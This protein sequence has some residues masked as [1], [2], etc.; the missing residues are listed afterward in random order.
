MR[1]AG[2][3]GYY[4]RV[5]SAGTNNIVSSAHYGEILKGFDIRIVSGTGAGQQ[6]V[7]TAVSDPVVAD[8]GVATSVSSTT[9]LLQITDS[10]KNWT[11]NQWVG[12]QVRITYGSGI[13]QVR[14]ILYNSNNTL[15][16]GDVNLF[17]TNPWDAMA[18][19]ATAISSTVG[20]QTVYNIESSTITVD[21]NWI[22]QP[23]ATSRFMV[24][25]GGVFLYTYAT[26]ISA[27]YD[28][29]ADTWYYRSTTNL[30]SGTPTDLTIE[31][32][33]ENSTIWEKGVAT[34]G[35]T[36]TLV[37]NTKQ[38]KV[39][40][41]A[42]YYIR[43]YSGTGENQL[44]QIV[45]NTVDTITWSATGTA[46]DTTS[47][48]LIEGLDAGT[49]SSATSTT[50]VDS[51]KSWGVDRWKNMAVYITSGTGMGQQRSIVSNTSTTLTV[52]PPWNTNPD[53]TSTYK[54]QGDS[55]K[56]F[57]MYGG[58]S[59]LVVHNL[60]RDSMSYGREYENGLCRIGSAR[61]GSDYAI[62]IT[63]TTRSG[64]VATV[65]TA[66]PHNFKTGQSITHLGA[67]GADATLYNITASITVTSTTT[68]TYN[69][70]G[71]PT[72]NAVFNSLS[73]SVLV[74]AAKNWTTN[75]WAGYIVYMNTNQTSPGTSTNTV[76]AFRIA[77][78][79]SN[80]LTFQAAGTAPVNGVSRY[81]IST[82]P[83]IG[84]IDSGLAF[85]AAVTTA[86]VTA[87]T[88]YSILGIPAR[89][90][91]IELNWNQGSSD[92]SKRG[93]FMFVARGGGVSG[94]D[95]LNLNTDTWETMVVSP[96]S[97]T[98]TTG[99]MYVYD[100]Q[101]RIYFTK[102][103]TLR[104]YYLDV[105]TNMIHGAGVYPYAAGTAIIGNRMEIFETPDHLK[106]LW[107][108]RHSAAECFR[109][110]LFY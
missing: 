64:T 50:L 18:P 34:S 2:A 40:Q 55:D 36:T 17:A 6:R 35:T 83:A 58:Q 5:I 25:S 76:Q 54:I 86:A 21:T 78:N 16:F 75:Q 70:S 23:D 79:T 14:K 74:D 39:N 97:E 37:D 101:D 84:A 42:G 66:V 49:T 57:V 109:C 105:N 24:Q 82:A 99:S 71:T 62:P 102:E 3:V 47:R 60:E 13:S 44:R 100:G 27:Y 110:L 51:A 87:N 77:S 29:A 108:N 12:Y 41:F 32:Q 28:I 65:T 10:T 88:T 15:T 56:L 72:A 43:I 33:T 91:G 8:A 31:R 93:R 80:T 68:Y 106:Y 69:M 95:R 107:L 67:T 22:T 46:P 4:G 30:S 7:V 52:S 90:T 92:L 11:V 20:S 59:A 19:L 38:W 94:F 1:F 26:G 89:G 9:S 63:S 61:Y 98:L 103:V 81:V 104:C 96:Q 45:S 85:S 73:T 53:S 48:Y